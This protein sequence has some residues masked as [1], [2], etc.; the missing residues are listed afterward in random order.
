MNNDV[1]N[2]CYAVGYY[3]GRSV[4]VWEHDAYES[5][6]EN[7]QQAYKDGYNRGVFDYCDLEIEND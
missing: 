5:W 6:S 3:Q 7:C 1:I 4:G 2:W